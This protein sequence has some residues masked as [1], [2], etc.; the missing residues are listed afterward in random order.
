MTNSASWPDLSVTA[1]ELLSAATVRMFLGQLGTS[2]T[3][4]RPLSVAFVRMT[5]RA[6]HDYSRSRD[7]V[8]KLENGSLDL[9][10]TIHAF[11]DF[12]NCIISLHRA[13]LFLEELK[14]NG[15]TTF[16][17]DSV[18]L[19]PRDFPVLAS[20]ARGRLRDLRDAIVH[21]DE[22]IKDGAS[23]SGVPTAPWPKD[24]VIELEGIRVGL[25]ELVGWLNHVAVVA[26]RMAEQGAN[27]RTARTAS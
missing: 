2:G 19:K 11:G 20:D 25:S 14:S 24:G 15:L 17:G 26:K 27:E 9:L 8:A 1:S 21:M 22:R 4:A 12:E 18:S 7:S 23:P 6:L 16:Q 10:T 3:K 5:A 13:L